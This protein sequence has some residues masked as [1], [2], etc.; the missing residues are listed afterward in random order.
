MLARYRTAVFFW[1]AIGLSVVSLALLF[2]LGSI[3]LLLVAASVVFNI[4][5]VIKS[6]REGFVRSSELRRAHEPARHFNG[7]QV[8]VLFSFVIVQVTLGAYVLLSGIG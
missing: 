3:L 7:V 2:M 1:S 8:F 4:W 5:T 6:D